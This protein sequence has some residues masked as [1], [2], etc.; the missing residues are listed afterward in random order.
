MNDRAVLESFV[1]NL[2]VGSLDE[3]VAGDLGI[4]RKVGNKT[5][6]RTFRGLDRAHSSI[7]GVMYVTD[8]EGCSV[9]GETA[10]TESGDSSLVSQLCQRV[11][12]VHEL[13]KRGR[14]E[15][16]ADSG[17]NGSDV[18]KCLRGERLAVL[19]GHSLLDDLVHSCK[20]DAQLVLEKLADA[21]ESSVAEMVN[22][23][24]YAH[25]VRQGEQ[26]VDGSENIF[27]SNM[28]GAELADSALCGGD[29]SLAVVSALFHDL[30]QNG[31]TC[32]FGNA[33]LFEVI[34]ENVLRLN[35][36]V[37]EYLCLLG[38]TAAKVNLCYTCALDSESVILC[39]SHAVLK[40]DLARDGADSGT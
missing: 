25:A 27:L 7:V 40:E 5:D 12:L 36:A 1:N 6:V 23:V 28:L 17:N 33:C 34:A 20:A 15:E 19:N 32:L 9:T 31:K 13:R 30:K 38:L 29:N 37:G 4:S 16:L 2:S 8:L 11:V 22:V 14:T 39:K 35:C 21:A 24:C 18:D 10:G 26:I 3:S